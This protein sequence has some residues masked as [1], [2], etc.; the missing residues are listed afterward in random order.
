M[1]I[2][3]YIDGVPAFSTKNEAVQWGKV[4]LNIPGFH[5]HPHNGSKIFMAGFTHEHINIVQN[6]KIRE[7]GGGVLQNNLAAT[8][9]DQLITTMPYN[10]TLAPQQPV[11]PEPIQEIISP[12]ITYPRFGGSSSGGSSSGGGGG[13]GGGGGY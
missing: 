13:G 3:K 2:I 8:S 1:A 5:T 9:P 4:N 12:T 6:K 10:P 11:S 7:S